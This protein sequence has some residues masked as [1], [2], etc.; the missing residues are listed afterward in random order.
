MDAKTIFHLKQP[1]INRDVKFESIGNGSVKLDDIIF[2]RQRDAEDYLESKP[3][4]DF[5]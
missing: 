5:R 1:S 3:R 4:K 2:E